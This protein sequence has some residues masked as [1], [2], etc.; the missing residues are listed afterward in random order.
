MAV[1]GPTKVKM[2]EFEDGTFGFESTGEPWDEEKY[3]SSP[4]PAEVDESATCDGECDSCMDPC[5]QEIAYRAA[6]GGVGETAAAIA[7]QD[8]LMK[9]LKTVTAEIYGGPAYT[10]RHSK[11]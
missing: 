2:V 9:E 3:P 10:N 4:D 7:K 5:D 8:K 6:I 1:Q 11:K